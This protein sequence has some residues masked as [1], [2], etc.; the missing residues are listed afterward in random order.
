MGD[1]QLPFVIRTMRWDDVPLVMVIEQES[2]PLPWS[3]YTYRHE[4]TENAHSHYIVIQAR[5]AGLDTRPWWRRMLQ[6]SSM[7]I[8]GYGGYWLI[9]DEAHISTIAVAAPWRGR[10]L[11]ELLLSAMIEQAQARQATMV[12]LEVRVS[13]RVAQNLYQKYGLVITGTRPR[14]YRDNDEDAYIMTVE[15]VDS[16]E[17]R[18]RFAEM[19]ASLWARLRAEAIAPAGQK[20]AARL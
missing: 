10:G 14:Y 18:R 11:G 4:L 8:V 3:S 13:N 9:T 20:L 15:R 17:Y 12:T 19:Q 6:P 2:F 7:P 5:A 1:G 16:Q